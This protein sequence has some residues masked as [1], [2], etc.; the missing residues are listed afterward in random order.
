[1]CGC[2]SSLRILRVLFAFLCCC[3]LYSGVCP[4]ML[5]VAPICSASPQSCY[6]V[7]WAATAFVQQLQRCPRWTALQALSFRALTLARPSD[8]LVSK[9]MRHAVV[10]VPFRMILVQR[11]QW[12]TSWGS[13]KLFFLIRDIDGP[14]TTGASV[15][16]CRFVV[17]RSPRRRLGSVKDMCNRLRRMRGRSH[18]CIH[19][20]KVLCAP[21]LWTMVYFGEPEDLV[22]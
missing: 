9:W 10:C 4:E 13:K 1:M 18:R 14:A 22:I 3:H 16:S 12:G 19:I 2:A 20:S 6:L 5:R 21:A 8:T 17:L 15:E 11:E 7:R